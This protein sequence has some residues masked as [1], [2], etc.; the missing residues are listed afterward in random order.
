MTSP[1]YR[2]EGLKIKN[3]SD[4]R[5][6]NWKAIWMLPEKNLAWAC[7]LHLTTLMKEGKKDAFSPEQVISIDFYLLNGI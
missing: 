3:D 5:G 1:F 2:D 4:S 7:G 6:Q